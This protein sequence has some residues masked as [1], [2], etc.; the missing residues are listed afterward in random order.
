MGDL[1]ISEMI[2][3]RN[4]S[5]NHKIYAHGLTLEQ[6]KNFLH[7]MPPELSQGE[8]LCDVNS[9][10][11]TSRESLFYPVPGILPEKL[12]EKDEIVERRILEKEIRFAIARQET[13]V[14]H[15]VYFKGQAGRIISV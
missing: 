8:D 15:A 11:V 1:P 12:V 4:I 14:E 10:K 3:L 9:T 7:V 5:G 13:Q 2:V 6:I